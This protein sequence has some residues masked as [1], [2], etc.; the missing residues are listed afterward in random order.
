M[1]LKFQRRV[2]SEYKTDSF[3]QNEAE[4]PEFKIQIAKTKKIR[5]N[6]ILFVRSRHTLSCTIFVQYDIQIIRGACIASHFKNLKIEIEKG[7]A[8]ILG[9]CNLSAY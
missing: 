1:E 6:V 2:V 4:N 7:R 5:E 3:K 8:Y 9:K